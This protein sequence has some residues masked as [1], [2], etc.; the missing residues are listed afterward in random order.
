MLQP[1]M[2]Q[3]GMPPGYQ[4]YG[5]AMYGPNYAGFGAR[6]GAYIID[7]LIGIL[8]DIPA[9]VALFAGPRHYVDCTVNGDP[10]TCHVPTGGTIG[11]TAL[12]ALAGGLAYLIIYCRMVS[13]GHSWG[14]KATGIRVADANTGQNISAGRAFGRQL[15]K[16]LSGFL[17]G[18]GYWWMLWDPRKQTWHDKI[19]STVVVRA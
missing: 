15:A 16:I 7:G 8:F 12:L 3:P 17:C 9:I 11:L 13:R 6:L 14:Q 10:G 5:A 2:M 4:P 18:L 1:G 19:V